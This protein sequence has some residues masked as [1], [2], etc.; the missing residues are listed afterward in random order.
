MV[1]QPSALP[2]RVIA[3]LGMHRSGTSCVTG[4]LQ[5]YG[6][7]LGEHSTWNRHNTRGNRENQTIVDLNDAVLTSSGGNWLEPPDKVVWQTEHLQEARRILATYS[8][9]PLFGFKDPRTLLTID[10]WRSVL[11]QRL[12][13]V[14]VYRNPNAVANSLVTRDHME[15][16]RALQCWQHYNQRL[17]SVRQQQR[18]PILNFDWPQAKFERRVATVARRLNLEKVAEDSFYTPDLKH[19]SLTAEEESDWSTEVSSTWEKLRAVSRPPAQWL[20]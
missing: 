1:D 6:L 19:H 17:L 3:V 8:D 16:G 12:S 2:Q 10:G 9:Q 5:N 14:G 7:Y 18:F 4:C 20:L 13:Y 11:Q 15:T